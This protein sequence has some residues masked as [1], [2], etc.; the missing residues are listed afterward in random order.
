M[1]REEERKTQFQRLYS[2]RNRARRRMNKHSNTASR[3]LDELE[4]S[5]PA[6][7]YEALKSVT[8][9]FSLRLAYNAALTPLHH[10]RLLVTSS[11]YSHRT[12]HSKRGQ[13]HSNNLSSK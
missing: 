10:A 13:T 9:N 2:R 11:R 5:P 7:Y 1:G 12:R 3:L 4:Q 6:E 8:V